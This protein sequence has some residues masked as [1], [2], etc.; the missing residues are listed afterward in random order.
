M[1]NS[2]M[3]TRDPNQQTAK[4]TRDPDQ[5]TAK[6]TRDPNQRTAKQTTKS[7]SKRNSPESYALCS[8]SEQHSAIIH[9]TTGLHKCA[10]KKG[11]QVL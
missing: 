11:I 10:N 1:W 3:K 8:S 6:Q 4:Q 7:P 5:Q 2:E 9:V